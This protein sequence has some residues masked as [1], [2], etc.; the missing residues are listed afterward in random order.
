MDLKKIFHT[1]RYLK[2]TQIFHQLKDRIHKP[3]LKM[4]KAP[5]VCSITL[6]VK[7]ISKPRCH[8]GDDRFTF[9]NITDRF[10]SWE[11]RRN[12]NLWAF[13]LNYMDWLN[14]DGLSA[15]EA[16]RWIDRYIESMQVNGTGN[17]P[18]PTALRCMNWIRLFTLHPEIKKAGYDDALFSQCMLLR[19]R[20]EYKLLANHLLEELFALLLAAL[21]FQDNS[22]YKKAK[23]GLKKELREQFLT[24]GAHFEQSPMYHCIMTDRLLDCINYVQSY[25][26]QVKDGDARHNHDFAIDNDLTL[27]LR[28]TACNALGHL[29]AIV[30]QD[31]TI[32]LMNDAAYNIAPTAQ[33]LFDYAKKLGMEWTKKTLADCGYR[34]I[35]NGR[36]ELVA[37]VGK[38]TASYQPGHTHADTLSF[39]LRIDGKPFIVDTGT[40]TYDKGER[41]NYERS[42]RAHNTVTIDNMDNCEVWS[43][44]RVGKRPRV[45]IKVDDPT[46]II[47]RHDGFGRAITHERWFFACDDTLKVRDIINAK[48]AVSRLH[49]AEGTNVTLRDNNTIETDTAVIRLEGATDITL[50]SDFYSTQYNIKKKCQVAEISFNQTLVHNIELK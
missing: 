13:N 33:E 29:E 18:Y 25:D 4:M 44:F 3:G 26:R 36:M 49:F 38:I 17:D 46:D 34:K 24:D 15:E 39:E 6:K 10:T 32:P 20:L 43:G 30:Y 22:L 28:H 42:S 14:Q 1:L 23:S 11:E 48:N 37:K 27:L 31:G 45:D 21:Y 9:I 35:S 19:K 5:G 41:R 16:C 40:S 7:P 50:T 12:G 2:A 47:A 8:E